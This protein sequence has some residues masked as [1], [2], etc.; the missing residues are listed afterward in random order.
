M[1]DDEGSV[2]GAREDGDRVDGEARA[3]GHSRP[4]RSFDGHPSH[5]ELGRGA[6]DRKRRPWIVLGSVV[7][8]VAAVA[9]FGSFGLSRDPEQVRS[10][11]LTK[12][13]PAF[14]LRSLDGRQV[15]RLADFPGQVVVLNFWAS[16]CRPCQI[17]HP[18]F[19]AAW[20]RF[21]DQGVVFVGVLYQDTVAR[22]LAYRSKRGG[23]WPVVADPDGKTAL[24]YG[25]FG[26]PE[27]FFIGADG[28][29]AFKQI[30]ATSYEVLTER[31]TVLLEDRGR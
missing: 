4:Y 5:L 31:V 30:G 26:V 10:A 27:T 3:S 11:L 12:A 20:R 14:A 6:F 8:A 19:Q 25:V 1:S 2:D 24:A 9:V 29:V 15:V 17:E 28:K 22:G 7:A 13:A 21:R 16:W 18:A 23:D